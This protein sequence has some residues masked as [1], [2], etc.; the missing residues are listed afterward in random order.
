MSF[1]GMHWLCPCYQP[2]ASTGLANAEPGTEKL[3][4]CNNSLNKLLLALTSAKLCTTRN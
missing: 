2:A 4:A 1:L 3:D